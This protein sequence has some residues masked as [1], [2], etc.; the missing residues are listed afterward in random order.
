MLLGTRE[1]FTYVYCPSCEVLQIREIPENVSK[2]YPTHYN[3]FD[4]SSRL[5][6]WAKGRRLG[7]TLFRNNLP[8]FLLTHLAGPAPLAYF[9]KSIAGYRNKRILDVGCGKGQLLTE[10]RHAGFRD[11]TGIDPFL[12]H[13]ADQPGLRLLKQPLTELEGT[14]D[15]IMFN[16]ALE[17]VPDVAQTLANAADHLS[18]D[19]RLVVRIPVLAEAWDRY[20]VHWIQLDAPRHFHL[21]SKSGF[22]RFAQAR[23][24]DVLE[25]I[26]DSSELQFWGSEQYKADIPLNDPRSYGAG[27]TT[28]FT[29]DAI[30]NFRAEAQRLNAAG[31]GDSA[32]FLL[33]K[34][35]P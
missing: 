32:F 9:L 26:C 28:L 7:W 16:H 8:G 20:G 24:F 35:V 30:Q 21:F 34:R 29:P 1:T 22:E 11:L 3:F 2:F 31:R 15:V 4:P 10:M 27:G 33:K 14:F 18:T 6:L 19:G 12:E 23:G 25:S 17:H 13:G 5:K